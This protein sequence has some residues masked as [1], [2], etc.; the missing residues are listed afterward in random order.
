MKTALAIAAVIFLAL[1]VPMFFLSG[2]SPS[3]PAIEEGMPWQIE[4]LPEGRSRV[5]G[6]TL[7]TATLADARARF[8]GDLDV[9]ILGTSTETGALEAF[10]ENVRFGFVTG[11]LVLTMEAP[12]ATVKAMRERAAKSEYMETANAVRKF[13]LAAPDATAAD[14]LRIAA[15]AFIPAANLDEQ[16]VLQRF[17]QPAERIRSSEKIEHFLY[18]DKGLDILLDSERKE[19]LQYVAPSRFSHLRDPLLAAIKPKE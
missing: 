2:E 12:E 11:K 10:V 13:T 5:F 9:A 19:L 16:T 18:P 3:G 8:G 14:G 17:G 15:I 7:G 4:T 1:T 6:L